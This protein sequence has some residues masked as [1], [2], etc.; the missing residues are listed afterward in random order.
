[1]GPHIIKYAFIQNIAV[2]VNDINPGSYSERK[3]LWI[4]RMTRFVVH[5]D[6]CCLLNVFYVN[7]IVN[8]DESSQV[9]KCIH[10]LFTFK[11]V[12]RFSC[13]PLFI[14][15]KSLSIPIFLFVKRIW[16]KNYN[17]INIFWLF[18]K[19]IEQSTT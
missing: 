16:L 7:L 13:F 4:A 9:E 6:A 11:N 14:F 15:H 12:Q 18:H 10:L 17:I 19:C 3:W 8:I 5:G 2:I 1:M